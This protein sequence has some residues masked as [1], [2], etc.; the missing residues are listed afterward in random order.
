MLQNIEL[1]T[2]KGEVFRFKEVIHQ[3]L[4]ITFL[5]SCE[6]KLDVEH[7]K[8]LKL[9]YNT[10]LEK[11]FYPIVIINCNDT[12]LQKNIKKLKL[13]F[14]VLSDPS[15]RIAKR[16]NCFLKPIGIIQRSTIWF[17]EN[18][19]QIKKINYMS[20]VNQHITYLLQL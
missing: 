6:A 11:H 10:I 1:L 2:S 13:P 12:L 8:R 5:A 19:K 3:K 14:L 16:F 15:A 20:D 18:E 4:Q 17:E 9:A 7:L